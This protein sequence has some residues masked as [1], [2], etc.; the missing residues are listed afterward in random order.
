MN[1]DLLSSKSH[2]EHISNMNLLLPKLQ[3]TDF[4]PKH[5]LLCLEAFTTSTSL[6]D[7]GQI[8]KPSATPD[9]ALP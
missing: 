6:Q 2:D 5:F 7:Q 3:A 4:N 8:S 9:L 1:Y